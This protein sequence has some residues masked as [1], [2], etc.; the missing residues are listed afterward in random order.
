MIETR[1][2]SGTTRGKYVP[3]AVAR[4]FGHMQKAPAEQPEPSVRPSRVALFTSGDANNGRSC[5]R[6]TADRG[7]RRSDRVCKSPAP[8]RPAADSP[9]RRPAA[10]RTGT[11][12]GLAQDRTRTLHHHIGFRLHQALPFL[13]VFA[14]E[15]FIGGGRGHAMFV[16]LHAAGDAQTAVHIDP[17]ILEAGEP[18]LDF[19]EIRQIV[20]LA[21]IRKLLLG[22]H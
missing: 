13:D 12:L 8:P 17:F 14:H 4:W 7:R 22:P 1:I 6:S 19:F 5:A 18:A 20:N 16:G 21:E 2:P 15:G 10:V 9:S 3:P 11:S